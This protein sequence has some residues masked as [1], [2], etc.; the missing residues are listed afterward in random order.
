[1]L[2]VIVYLY[3]II[4]N[5]KGYRVENNYIAETVVKTD[6]YCNKDTNEV[7]L[8]RVIKSKFTQVSLD[9]TLPASRLCNYYSMTDEMFYHVRDRKAYHSEAHARWQNKEAS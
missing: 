2:I 3:I 1:M 8:S 6:M 7:I 9:G 5:I 4:M